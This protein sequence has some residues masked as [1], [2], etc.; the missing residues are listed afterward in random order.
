MSDREIDKWIELT[1]ELSK[2][3]FRPDDD[4]QSIVPTAKGERLLRERRAVL[5]QVSAKIGLL[6]ELLRAMGPSSI[7]RC[8]VYA[9]A[10]GP[11]LDQRRQIEQVNE[12]L[13]TLGVISHQ[14][15][16]AE[17]AYRDADH[18]LESF[19]RGDYQVL[20]A[21]KVLDE[22]IDIPQT[23]TAF[24]LAS[25]TVRREWVQRR[26]R[27]LRK[28]PGKALARLHDF[29]VV[30]PDPE[31]AEGK[32]IL[33]SEL[34]RA[35]EFASLAENEWD[36]GGP[37]R[38]ISR[39]ESVVWEPQDLL[40]AW[41]GPER[42]GAQA[43][44]RTTTVAAGDGK[45]D[46]PDNVAKVCPRPAR[47][48]S[49]TPSIVSH[50]VDRYTIR[51]GEELAMVMLSQER[52]SE[53]LQQ[54]MVLVSQRAPEYREGLANVLKAAL[55]AQDEGSSARRRQERIIRRALKE[56]GAKVLASRENG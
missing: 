11:V 35:V 24:L 44:S 52:I 3:G 8:L 31:S 39:Y 46:T 23:D 22:G 15:T 41:H 29:I 47:R 20:T 1:E 17:T 26:G 36:D 4:G 38:I 7:Q 27:I 34:Q 13:S 25:S 37:R 51:L 50:W 19:G 53:V 56:L 12:M 49:A 30:P 9:S 5:E 55:L 18:W 32:S 21:M 10:K 33:K 16:S 54:Q 45:T 40:T 2:A 43:R 6:C 42:N 48:P 28:T 14:F